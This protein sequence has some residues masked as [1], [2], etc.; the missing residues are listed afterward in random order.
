MDLTK[1]PGYEEGMEPEK[2]LEL[3]KAFEPDMSGFVS[4][5]TAD[6]L[7]SEAAEY[8]RKLRERMSAEE[9]KAVED[10]EANKKLLDELEELVKTAGGISLGRL[11]QARE[12]PEHATYI[13][14]GKLKELKLLCDSMLCDLVV[15]DCEL[16]PSQIRNV[17]ALMTTLR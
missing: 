11:I 8:K 14:S 17:E 16:S 6:K 13:G 9:Q 10:A 2:V 15:F 5:S 12:K 1:I 7:A 3:V 4:K